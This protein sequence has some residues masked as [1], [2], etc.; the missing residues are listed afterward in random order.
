MRA[1]DSE[2]RA[3]GLFSLGYPRDDGGEEINARIRVARRD[4][5]SLRHAFGIDEYPVSGLLSG[6]FH[7]TGAYQRP[8]G[9]GAMTINDGVAYGE[10]FQ[11]ATSPLRFD[12]TGVRLD[13]LNLAK[14]T[15][16]VTGAAYVGWDST[17]SFNADGR[18]IPVERLTF[19]TFP[20][21]PLSGLAE[22]TATGSGT[23]ESPRN[24]FKFRVDDLFVGEEGVGAGHRHAGAARRRAERR[25]S[26][27][28]RRAWR[29]PAPA[30]SR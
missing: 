13:N 12:G 29:S 1:G 7:L 30:A 22:F 6:E 5:D 3:D 25:R 20:R 14:D 16:T 4:L 28:R 27:P 21:A 2:I 19:V 9:F 17:Y 8:V 10:P 23:F 24:D 15:G 18:R 11:K 26:T